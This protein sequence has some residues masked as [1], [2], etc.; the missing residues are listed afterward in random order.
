[1]PGAPDS[2]SIHSARLR[3]NQS[4]SA[5]VISMLPGEGWVGADAA[6]TFFCSQPVAASRADAAQAADRANASRRWIHLT[7][8]SPE[9]SNSTPEDATPA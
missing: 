2:Q 6:G 3:R 4:M 1:M 7:L 9:K 8:L 5:C